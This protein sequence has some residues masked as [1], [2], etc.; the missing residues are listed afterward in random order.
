MMRVTDVHEGEATDDDP[1][2]ILDLEM[3]QR[4]HH[5]LGK[6][7]HFFNGLGH[8]AMFATRCDTCD[9]TFFPPREYC[10]VDLGSTSWYELPG[11]GSVVAA[12]VVHSPPPFGGIEAPYVLGS[13]RL[14][15]VDGGLTHRILGT[16]APLDGAKVSVRFLDGPQAHPLLGIAFETNQQVETS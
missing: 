2:M 13:I 6:A 4:Y 16:I 9:A 5:S 12:I 11:T 15:G 3:S 8:G 10:A 1:S 7:S 14:D